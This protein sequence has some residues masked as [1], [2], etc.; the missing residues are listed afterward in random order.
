[1]VSKEA[2]LNALRSLGFKYKTRS[3][4]MELHKQSGTTKRVQVRRHN[5]HTCE[6]AASVLR[7][8]GMPQ[9][10]IDA[11]LQSVTVTSH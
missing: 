11:F 1:M 6:Y 10:D 4:R 3:D 8:A 9:A 7:S 2:L 5:M